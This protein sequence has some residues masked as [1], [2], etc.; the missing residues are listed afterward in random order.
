MANLNAN[1]MAYLIPRKTRK[2]KVL[3]NQ[4][5]NRIKDT[6]DMRGNNYLY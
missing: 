2:F 1:H 5:S 3:K 4:Q 6:V